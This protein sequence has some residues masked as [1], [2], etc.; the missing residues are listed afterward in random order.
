MNDR[1]KDSLLTN[2]EL[3]VMQVVWKA[4]PTP[5]TVREAVEGLNDERPRPL[6]YNTVQTMLTILRDKGI[7]QVVP[8]EGRAYRY[9][10]LRSQE[11]VS[12]SMVGDLVE[13]L[14]GG[15]FQPLLMHLVEQSG[16]ERN[17]LEGLRRLI[18]EHLEDDIDGG[19]SA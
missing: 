2:L 9:A 15:S 12:N 10:A 11:E 19:A 13:R 3:E 18:D 17:D 4:H 14:F 1:P 16:L 7:V 6:A 5:L 8:G